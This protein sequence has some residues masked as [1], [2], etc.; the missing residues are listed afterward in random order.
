MC[1]RKLRSSNAKAG[2]GAWLLAIASFCG[3]LAFAPEEQRMQIAWLSPLTVTTLV[4]FVLGT[5]LIFFSVFKKV[6]S[7]EAKTEIILARRKHLPVIE[8]NLSSYLE[9]AEHLASTT[10][11]IYDLEKYKEMLASSPARWF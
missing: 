1:T 11:V 5:I 2:F 4:T 9:R 8:Q 3:Q 7:N 10:G 6:L